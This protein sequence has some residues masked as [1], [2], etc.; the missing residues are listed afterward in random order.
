MQSD[1]S[2]TGNYLLY[3]SFSSTIVHSF[4][5]FSE[6]SITKLV[7]ISCEAA[8]HP[9]FVFQKDLLLM[10]DGHRL[11]IYVNFLI[12]DPHLIVIFKYSDY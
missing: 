11:L 8:G 5:D 12:S 1:A 10:T 4:Q 9:C 6:K 2:I 7:T 3:N